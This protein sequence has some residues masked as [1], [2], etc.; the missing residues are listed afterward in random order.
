[1]SDTQAPSNE[2]DL[3]RVLLENAELVRYEHGGARLS[4]PAANRATGRALIA[5][6]YG[7]GEWREFFMKLIEDAGRAQSAHEPC[8]LHTVVQSVV[9]WNTKYPS[10][11]VY[12]YGTI[13]TIA[14]EMDV[15]FEQAKA[16]LAGTS[17]PPGDG[18]SIAV[19][20]D[21]NDKFQWDFE[22]NSDHPNGAAIVHA[23]RLAVVGNAPCAAPSTDL[24]D[25][26]YAPGNYTSHCL[27]CDQY[28]DFVDKRCRCCRSCAQKKMD[29][30]FA[31]ATPTKGDSQ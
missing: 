22:N 4:I 29:K 8:A 11:R 31:V 15:I 27:S 19:W 30:A 24:V 14:A 18:E 21:A 25:Y 12:D 28:I 26:G 5:D 10:G 16:A 1:M 20:I 9:D 17:Q 13:K 6:F 3:L 7:E 23:P 2:R